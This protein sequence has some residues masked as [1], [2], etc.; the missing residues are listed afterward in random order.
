M[1]EFRLQYE[2]PRPEPT[3]DHDPLVIMDRE[4]KPIVTIHTDGRMTV[5]QPDKAEQAA[6]AF[7]NWVTQILTPRMRLVEPIPERT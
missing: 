5:D 4:G 1:S 6:H 3:R 2:E 7:A